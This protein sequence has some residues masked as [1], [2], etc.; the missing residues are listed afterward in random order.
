MPIPA[1]LT[2]KQLLSLIDDLE[3]TPNDKGRILG[4]VGIT[5]VGAGL[6]VAAAGTAAAAVGATCH[7]WS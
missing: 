4:D 2:K 3:S 7:F 1:K 5:V 6:G